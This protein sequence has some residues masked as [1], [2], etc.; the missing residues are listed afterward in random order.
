MASKPPI[1][2]VVCVATN[3]AFAILPNTEIFCAAT[4]G[5]SGARGGHHD[6]N[7]VGGIPGA[8]FFHDVRAVIL[9]R[10][11]A[12][13]QV[14]SRLLVGGARRELLQHFTLAAR[15]GFATGKAQRSNVGS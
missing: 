1:D 6:P 11:G 14:T 4:F 9:N 3:P 7:Q 10:S 8:E 5:L 12:D 13:S 2:R 15:Q